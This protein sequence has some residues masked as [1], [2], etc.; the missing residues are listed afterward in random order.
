M[1]AA[2][3]GS[4]L[5]VLSGL[6]VDLWLRFERFGATRLKLNANRRQICHFVFLVGSLMG[7]A[8]RP[9]STLWAQAF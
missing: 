9:S 4:A 7:M 2:V 8:A 5:D 3:R 1:Q 6:E